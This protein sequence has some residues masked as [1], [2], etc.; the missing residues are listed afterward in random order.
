[1]PQ[2]RDMR[3]KPALVGWGVS[4]G[5]GTHLA[6][7][8]PASADR[9]APRRRAVDTISASPTKAGEWGCRN[10]EVRPREPGAV[11]CC[12]CPSSRAVHPHNEIIVRPASSQSRT[13]LAVG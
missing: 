10:L 2:L 1:M 13:R 4:G 8:N 12:S 6:A 9:R 11:R 3:D 7:V 5:G